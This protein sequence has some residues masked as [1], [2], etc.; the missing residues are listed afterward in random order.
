M[1]ARISLLFILAGREI[2]FAITF[3]FRSLV[4]M[5]KLYLTPIQS[6]A[7]FVHGA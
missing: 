4:V 1:R 2:K 6:P 5:R 3:L 7:D